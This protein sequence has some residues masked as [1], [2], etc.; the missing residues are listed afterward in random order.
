MDKLVWGLLPVANR[1]SFVFEQVRRFADTLDQVVATELAKNVAGFLGF[2]HV[3]G[4]Q[5]ANRLADCRNRLTGVE[6]D[7]VT[8]FEGLVFLAPAKNGDI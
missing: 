5:P 4:N 1:K 6:M 8:F 3:A 2:L 7:D